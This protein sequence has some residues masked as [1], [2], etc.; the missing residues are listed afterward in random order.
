MTNLFDNQIGIDGQIVMSSSNKK[1]IY[2]SITYSPLGYFSS[3]IDIHGYEK[4]L[5]LNHLGYLWRDDYSQI[6]LGLKFQNPESWGIIRNSA[7]ILEADQEENSQSVDL[8]KTI[9]LNYDVQFTNFWGIGGGFYKILEHFD[10][11]K[12]IHDYYNNMFGP[13]IYIPEVI[14]SY[15]YLSSD[16]HQKL[17]GSICGKFARFSC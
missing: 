15:F 13:P 1:G 2:G 16:K 8:G 17:S 5:N 12:I 4:G 14:G 10:D 11:R 9:E 6:K 3:W 7:I